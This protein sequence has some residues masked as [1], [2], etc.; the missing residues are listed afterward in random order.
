MP[1]ISDHWDLNSC[2]G[3]VFF[4]RI[5]R[6]GV[7]FRVRLFFSGN[8]QLVVVG[9]FRRSSF[10][11]AIYLLFVTKNTERGEQAKGPPAGNGEIDDFYATNV[12][13]ISS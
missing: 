9:F 12:T 3:G 10:M 2:D 11:F 13:A 5:G 6:A 1:E 4:I 7:S 8:Y